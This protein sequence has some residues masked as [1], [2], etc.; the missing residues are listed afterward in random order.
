[1]VE[2]RVPL[3]TLVTATNGLAVRTGSTVLEVIAAVPVWQHW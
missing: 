2:L 3:G 1:M